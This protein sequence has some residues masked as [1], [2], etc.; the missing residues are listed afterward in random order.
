[1]ENRT[2][3]CRNPRC[4]LYGC[5]APLTRLKFCAWQFGAARF[6]CQVC[7][8]RVAARTGTA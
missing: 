6:Q 7:P 2:C 4:P 1:M 5:R 8:Q 3:F